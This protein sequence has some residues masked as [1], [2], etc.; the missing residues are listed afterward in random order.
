MSNATK[1]NGGNYHY[2]NAEGKVYYVSLNDATIEVK[3]GV[4][5]VLEKK[6]V[7]NFLVAYYDGVSITRVSEQKKH[8]FTGDE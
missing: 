8:T 7:F 6:D 5:F 1:S 2:A 3:D 4:S